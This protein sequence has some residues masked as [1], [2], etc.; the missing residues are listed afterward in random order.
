VTDVLAVQRAQDDVLL[1]LDGDELL[2]VDP[3]QLLLESSGKR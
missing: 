2:P 1:V 3:A